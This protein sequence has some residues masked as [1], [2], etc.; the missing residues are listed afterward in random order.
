MYAENVYIILS[1]TNF[2]K[3]AKLKQEP[4]QVSAILNF[5]FVLNK[6]LTL[7]VKVI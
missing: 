7:T 5:F 6:A 1:I 4:Q 3:N 2:G